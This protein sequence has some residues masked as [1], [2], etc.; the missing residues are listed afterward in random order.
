LKQE[1]GAMRKKLR[2]AVEKLAKDFLKKGGSYD[3]YFEKIL[4]KAKNEKELVKAEDLFT[5]LVASAKTKKVEEKVERKVERVERRVER[6]VESVDKLV[7]AS[8]FSASM[9]KDIPSGSIRFRW[10]SEEEAKELVKKAKEIESIVGHTGTAELFS[11]KLD[12]EIP[13]RRVAYFAKSGDKILVGQLL[14]RLPEGAVLSREELKKYQMKW[15]L[16]EVL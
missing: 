15:I 2:E 7:V 11:A 12:V 9:L 5:Q 13:T 1:G 6:E 10:L 8:A 16:I 14:Q 4:K 3:K